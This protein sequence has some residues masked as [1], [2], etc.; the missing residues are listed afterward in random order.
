MTLFAQEFTV[1]CN[2]LL[3]AFFPVESHDDWQ[4]SQSRYYFLHTRV[5]LHTYYTSYYRQET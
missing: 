5:A 1:F 4:G 3:H 2:V